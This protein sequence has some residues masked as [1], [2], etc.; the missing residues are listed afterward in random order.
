MDVT[1]ESERQ[2]Q[3]RLLLVLAAAEVLWFAGE[4]SFK[5]VQASE[6]VLKDLSEALAVVRDGAGWSIL[7]RADIADFER[8]TISSCHFSAEIPNSGF[9]GWLASEFEKGLA[10][11]SSWFVVR[12]ANAEA[13]SITGEFRQRSAT[14]HSCCSHDWSPRDLWPVNSSEFFKDFVEC[15]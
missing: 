13:F 8:F 3:E 10:R 12:I 11:A 15:H 2:T 7:K 4:Y 14:R 6:E 1:I 5:E 9:V